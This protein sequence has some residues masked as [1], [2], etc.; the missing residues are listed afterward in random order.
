MGLQRLLAT[1]ACMQRLPIVALLLSLAGVSGAQAG[2]TVAGCDAP[3]QVLAKANDAATKLFYQRVLKRADVGYSARVAPKGY[4]KPEAFGARGDGVADDTAAL[5]R[6]LDQGMR[7][8]LSPHRVYR[9]TR[10]LEMR[11]GQA[12]QSAGSA[13]LLMASGPDGFSNAFAQRSD[14][15][16]YTERGTGLRLSG[17]GITLSD[18]FIVKAFEDDRYVIGIDVVQARA[19]NIRRVRLRGFSVAPGIVTI[20][21]SHGVTVESSLI[22]ASCTRSTTVPPDVGSFQITGISVDDSRVEGEGSTGLRL[23]NNVIAG[24]NMAPVTYRRDQSD[25][26]NFAAMGSG[27]DSVIAQND[28]SGVDEGVDLFGT[29]IK[30][31][32]NRV[33]A[34][35]VALKLVHGANG[36]IAR[37]NEFRGGATLPAVGVYTASPPE[38]GRQV[39]DVILEGNVISASRQRAGLEVDAEG[40]FPPKDIR[41]L[42]NIFVVPACGDRE[43]VC[44]ASQCTLA[45]NTRRAA[46]GAACRP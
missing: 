24:L 31:E 41:V 36:I 29:G 18:L 25:G 19:V 28:I 20:R 44:A 10:R 46:A 11:S 30:V 32:R 9:L 1:M 6:A 13:T 14:T 37:R 4:V 15:G 40:P 21:S 26:I 45:G 38:A 22:H 7:V 43:L 5:Q 34:T 23:F 16:I 3:K 2:L 35:S 8:W 39:H 12:L 17:A 27:H 33:A 42:G